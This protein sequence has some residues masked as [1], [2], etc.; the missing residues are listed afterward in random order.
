MPTPQPMD[1]H[2]TDT[3]LAAAAHDARERIHERALELAP[4]AAEKAAEAGVWV[5]RERNR[6]RLKMWLI[7]L[8]AAFVTA[9]AIM[10]VRRRMASQ[11]TPAS[12]DA[13]DE[14][15]ER[16]LTLAHDDEDTSAVA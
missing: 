16:D 9:A 5:S 11:T 12:E 8:L 14:S 15:G 10:I 6:A 4:V 13:V 1:T 7:G 2:P 3:A